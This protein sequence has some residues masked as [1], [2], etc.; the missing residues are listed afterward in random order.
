MNIAVIGLGLIGGSMAK[1][2]KTK[3]GHMVFGKDTNSETMLMAS[4]SGAI[5]KE[6]DDKILGDCDLIFLCLTPNVAIN[7]LEENKKKISSKTTVV[8]FCGIK[9]DVCKKLSKIAEEG[10]FSYVGGHP[11]AG[12]ERG[13]FKNSS[14]D[15]FTGASMILT[16]DEKTLPETLETL[17]S[18]FYDVG[19]SRIVYSTPEEH[20]RIIAYTSQLAHIVSS[21]YI[22]SPEAARQRGFSAGSFRDMTRVAYLDEK[23]WTELFLG[24][25]DYLTKELGILIS[26][27]EEYKSALESGNKEE[28]TKLLKE[29]REA[30]IVAGGN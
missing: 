26:H 6:I 8:D 24:D 20:D 27:L 15:L 30:K 12:K 17:S 18:L 10:N 1:G 29:G 19:F 9:R 23:M 11:M 5:D 7:W 14:P 4:L 21:A 25:A 2:I 3:T 16:P 22:K 28:L 13:G